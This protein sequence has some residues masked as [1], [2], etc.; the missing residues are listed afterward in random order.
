MISLGA[1]QRALRELK[2]TGAIPNATRDAL[3]FATL[4]QLDGGQ[5][6]R[7]RARKYN[8]IS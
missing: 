8:V 6:V 1:V 7:E 4:R 5:E 2:T 3:P